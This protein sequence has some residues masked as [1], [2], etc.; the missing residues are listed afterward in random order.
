MH[1][2]ARSRPPDDA[3][4]FLLVRLGAYAGSRFVEALEPLGIEPRHFGVLVRL[5][6]HEGSSQ[7]E[8]GARLDLNP[9][10]MVFLIDDLEGR[11]LVERRPN[12]DDRRRHALY[13]TEAG[14]TTLDRARV[15]A[16]HHGQAMGQGL[17]AAERRQ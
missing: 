5:V 3:F 10:R 14:R 7:Q 9:T 11:G 12:P 17:S 15:V 6:D 13:L 1:M 8:L 2:P 4:T 16:R